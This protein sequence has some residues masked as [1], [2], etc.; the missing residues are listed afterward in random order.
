MYAE[1]G[2]PTKLMTHSCPSDHAA[3]GSW[4]SLSTWV[5]ILVTDGE[6]LKQLNKRVNSLRS[7]GLL[8]VRDLNAQQLLSGSAGSS[9]CDKS[10]PDPSKYT[11]RSRSI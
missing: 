4:E 5:W 9:W 2:W 8:M 10:G 11:L 1:S 3:R 7:R 6:G